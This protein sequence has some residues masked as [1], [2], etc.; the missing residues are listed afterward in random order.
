MAAAEPTPD[1]QV[2]EDFYR[3][4]LARFDS[5]REPSELEEFLSQSAYERFSQLAERPERFKHMKRFLP[6]EPRVVEV[7]AQGE[8]VLV[9]L[10]A[11]VPEPRG[12]EPLPATGKVELLSQDG[13]K[14][15]RELWSF[16]TGEKP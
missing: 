3:L 15:D 11:K 13:W 9:T 12:L 14:V 8:R 16:E 6:Q 4:Y 1:K 2:V 7:K 10:R 5:A